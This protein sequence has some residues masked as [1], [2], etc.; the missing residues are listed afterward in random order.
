[1]WTYKQPYLPFQYSEKY[2]RRRANL[3][4]SN[5]LSTRRLVCFT[6]SGLSAGYGLPTWNKMVEHAILFVLQ[7]LAPNKAS[8]SKDIP[9]LISA[10]RN[11]LKNENG[12]TLHSTVETFLTIAE[13]FHADL[14]AGNTINDADAVLQL[15]EQMLNDFAEKN[16]LSA[17]ELTRGLRKHIANEMR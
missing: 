8:A 4:L 14:I 10:C 6:G 16:N 13:K 2:I 5:A 15:C 17:R 12:L 9:E 1:M 3:A 7:K 11:D